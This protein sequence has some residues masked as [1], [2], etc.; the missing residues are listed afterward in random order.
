M[1]IG[2]RSLVDLQTSNAFLVMRTRASLE[3]NEVSEARW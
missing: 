1:Y 2:R 3:Q